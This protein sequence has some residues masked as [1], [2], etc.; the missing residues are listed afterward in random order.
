MIYEKFNFDNTSQNVQVGYSRNYGAS[1][2]KVVSHLLWHANF[3]KSHFLQLT[4]V[5]RKGLL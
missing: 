5:S 3:S 2:P 4:P 1:G